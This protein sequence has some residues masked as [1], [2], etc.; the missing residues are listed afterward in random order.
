MVKPSNLVWKMS[1]VQDLVSWL[2]A[3]KEKTG[4]RMCDL[5]GRRRE[6]PGGNIEQ[7]FKAADPE[8]ARVIASFSLAERTFGIDG[9]F[10]RL[11]VER[12]ASRLPILQRPGL[13]VEIQRLAVRAL[14]ELAASASR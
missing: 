2:L 5:E 9:A 3:S 12:L 11:L 7:L 13:E 6:R 14:G 10:D 8:F 1:T 4:E